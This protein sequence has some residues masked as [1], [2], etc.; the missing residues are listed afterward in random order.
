MFTS[1]GQKMEIEENWEG[2]S[3]SAKTKSLPDKRGLHFKQG[4]FKIKTFS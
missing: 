1:G 2:F 3:I 4:D